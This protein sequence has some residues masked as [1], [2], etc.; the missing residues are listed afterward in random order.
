[1]L[2]RKPGARPMRGHRARAPAGADGEPRTPKAAQALQAARAPAPPRPPETEARGSPRLVAK[3]RRDSDLGRLTSPADAEPP[4]EPPAPTFSGQEHG[5]RPRADAQPRVGESGRRSAGEQEAGSLARPRRAVSRLIS[6]DL[7]LGLRPPQRTRM[8]AAAARR[9]VPPSQ[10]RPKPNTAEPNT[11]EPNTAEPARPSAPPSTAE[12][13]ATGADA[14]Q[15]SA[16]PAGPSSGM[17]HETGTSRAQLRQP[18]RPARRKRTRRN[19]RP[20]DR[21][22]RRTA[23]SRARQARRRSQ[24]ARAFCNH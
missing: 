1:M 6:P 16:C 15:I 3:P 11:A 24:A 21:P 5:T 23:S 12:P 10:A 19:H 2:P 7:T 22:R 14:P 20:R 18:R 17:A 8:R 9:Q 13:V 4:A